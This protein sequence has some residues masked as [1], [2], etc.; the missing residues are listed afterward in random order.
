MSLFPA[1]PI[2]DCSSRVGSDF[3]RLRLD[4][5]RARALRTDLGMPAKKGTTKAEPP[6]TAS[7]ARRP[8]RH[9]AARSVPPPS[10]HPSDPQSRQQRARLR[11]RWRRLVC[12]SPGA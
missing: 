2:R 1:H 8:K 4:S 6:S 7:I 3:D 5:G 11:R 9:T 12:G 10:S